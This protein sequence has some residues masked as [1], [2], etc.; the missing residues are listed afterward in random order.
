MHNV[1]TAFC[2]VASCHQHLDSTFGCEGSKRNCNF[3]MSTLSM[4]LSKT[5]EILLVKVH[6]SYWLQSNLIPRPFIP[7]FPPFPPLFAKVF[8]QHILPKTPPLL[9]TRSSSNARILKT[10]GTERT[11]YFGVNLWILVTFICRYRLPV[12]NDLIEYDFYTLSVEISQE[13]G[14]RGFTHSKA[15]NQ[16][17]ERSREVQNRTVQYRNIPTLACNLSTSRQSEKVHRYV[18]SSY[19]PTLCT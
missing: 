12:I 9:I 5:F 10:N 15:Y 6:A 16:F 18:P 8:T 7:P 4:I 19:P 14:S 11:F 3:T 17:K 1:L 2:L 13:V